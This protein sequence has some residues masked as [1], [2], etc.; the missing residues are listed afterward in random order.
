MLISNKQ[1]L[2]SVVWNLTNILINRLTIFHEN[3]EFNS[4]ENMLFRKNIVLEILFDNFKPFK[5]VH[6]KSEHTW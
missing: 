6:K 4:E 3:K 2:Y 5:I 1:S